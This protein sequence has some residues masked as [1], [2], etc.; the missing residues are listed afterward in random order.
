MGG[1]TSNN[2]KIQLPGVVELSA[3]GVLQDNFG[4]IL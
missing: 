1:T 3:D 4:G 2:I